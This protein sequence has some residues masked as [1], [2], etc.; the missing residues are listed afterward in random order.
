MS[1]LFHDGLVV[2]IAFAAIMMLGAWSIGRA[3]AATWRPYWHGVVYA[4]F[5][6]LAG[7]LVFWGLSGGDSFEFYAG[8]ADAYVD[9]IVLAAVA[10]VAYRLTLTRKM[11]TQYPWLYEQTGPFGWRDLRSPKA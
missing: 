11:V 6:A 9:V 10:W 1:Y 3:L 2:F 5:L 4:V 7:R 8:F